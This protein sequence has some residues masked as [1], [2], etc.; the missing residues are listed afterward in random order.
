MGK[1]G[2]KRQYVR[3]ACLC[4]RTRHA[5]ILYREHLMS[6]IYPAYD[7]SGNL[8]LS[9][10]TTNFRSQLMELPQGKRK[11]ILMNFRSPCRYFCPMQWDGQYLALSNGGASSE[12]LMF[13]VSISGSN[14]SVVN[15]ILLESNNNNSFYIKGGSLFSFDS[16]I[17][18]N[19]NEAVGVWAYPAGGGPSEEFYNITHGSPEKNAFVSL[20]Y[21]VAP[22]H[23]RIRK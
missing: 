22:P 13:Q 5:I 1:I 10:A 7:G 12:S 9:A 18:K 23:S 14:A 16:N 20:T 21:S 8:F 4:K 15:T 17:R 2:G 19:N 11:L 3:C 6:C